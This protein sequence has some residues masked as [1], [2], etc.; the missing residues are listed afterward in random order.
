MVCIYHFFIFRL[1]QQCM[2]PWCSDPGARPQR[3]RSL[4]R[5]LLPTLRAPPGLRLPRA[6]GRRLPRP[7]GATARS[8]RPSLPRAAGAAGIIRRSLP[9]A[10]APEWPRHKFPGAAA[11]GTWNAEAR[12]P[13]RRAGRHAHGEL[14][15]P[16][17]VL[18]SAPLNATQIPHKPCA[19]LQKINLRT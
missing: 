2:T 14:H 16:T 3:H 18:A 15:G 10:A 11:R 1:V 4:I 8:L 13:G 9:G 6:A 19:E 7:A 12:G 17:H 5:P